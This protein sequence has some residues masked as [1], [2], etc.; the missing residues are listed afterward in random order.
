MSTANVTEPTSSTAE[1]PINTAD[2][3]AST[4]K[5]IKQ[6]VSKPSPQE[7]PD[8]LIL[9]RATCPKLSD[10]AKGGLD[11][12]VGYSPAATEL[13]LRVVS[14]QSGGY[15]SKEWVPLTAI[16]TC[17]A[18]VIQSDGSFTA[19]TLVPAFI[20]KSQN[21]AGFLAAVLREEGLIA[22]AADKQH[23]LQLGVV[24]F[25]AWSEKWLKQGAAK[26]KTQQEVSA[27]ITPGAEETELEADAAVSSE[28]DPTTTKKTSPRRKAK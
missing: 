19:P 11:Y 14:N 20:S 6:K 26:S 25:S 10:R 12:Q 18:S 28:P 27:A 9:H 5:P 17:L 13:Y 7:E 22:K 4:A 8:L 21:N 3:S 24:S 16:Q 15:F 2:S 23:V 1:T